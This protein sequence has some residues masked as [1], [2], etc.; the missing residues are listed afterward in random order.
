M[1]VSYYVYIYIIEVTQELGIFCQVSSQQVCE[2]CFHGSHV[3]IRHLIS[4]HFLSKQ[5]RMPINKQVMWNHPGSI[6]VTILRRSSESRY[7]CPVP[8]EELGRLVVAILMGPIQRAVIDT[9]QVIALFLLWWPKIA[10]GFRQARLLS[11][12][13]MVERFSKGVETVDGKLAVRAQRAILT[14]RDLH[15]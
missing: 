4:D 14:E 7:F 8:A 9:S 5:A 3:E 2:G 13:E 6:S 11:L 15:V 1:Y 12:R 10:H